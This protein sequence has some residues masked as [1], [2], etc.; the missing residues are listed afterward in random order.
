ME[1]EKKTFNKNKKDILLVEEIS[2]EKVANWI[3]DLTE[4][5]FQNTAS[6][7]LWGEPDVPEEL[8]NVVSD[9]N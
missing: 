4:E 9:E 1:R 2:K 5:I 3:E 6:Q 8:L 7:L